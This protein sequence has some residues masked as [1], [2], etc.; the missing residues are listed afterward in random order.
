MA[1]KKKNKVGR[2]SK[3]SD[4][5][6]EI[7]RDYVD[8]FQPEP[9]HAIPMV[10]GLA[11]L[12]G[13]SRST[14]YEWADHEDKQEFSDIVERLTLIQ[15]RML[16]SGGLMN[17]YSSVMAKLALT[18]SHGYSDKTE[19]KDTTKKSIDDMTDEELDEFIAERTKQ[20]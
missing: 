19:T 12:I 18:S 13:V 15:E 11:E 16:L 8:N 2:P 4:E 14:V 5:V 20:G 9:F 6:L 17:T 7:A 3:Y 10:C 1:N